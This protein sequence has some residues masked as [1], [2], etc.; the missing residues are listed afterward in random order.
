MD[1]EVVAQNVKICISS[2]KVGG[3]LIKALS[4]EAAL[5]FQ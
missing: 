1:N 4:L 2:Q 3:K 5:T